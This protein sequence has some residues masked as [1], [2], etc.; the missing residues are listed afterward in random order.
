VSEEPPAVRDLLQVNAIPGLGV[1]LYRRLIERFGSWQN[2]R[3]ASRSDLLSVP[4]L[5]EDVARAIGDLDAFDVTG[6]IEAARHLGIQVVPTTD[7]RF[8]AGL[9]EF[10]GAPL[11]LYVRGELRP[12]DHLAIAMVGSRR[13]THYGR[14]QA[15]RLAYGLAKAGFCIVSGLARGIDAAAHRG[16]LRAGGRTLAVMGCGL[17]TVYPPEHEG[18]AGE[19]EANGALLSELP[20]D[21]PPRGSHF[22]SRNRIIAALSLGVIVV[23]AARRS[24]ALITARWALD[25]N[26]QVYAVPGPVDSRS[27]RGPHALIRDGAKLV[28]SVQDVV[29]ELGPLGIDVPTDAEETIDDPRALTL[30]GNEREIFNAVGNRPATIDAIVEAT[31]LPVPAVSSTL[32]VLEI[33]GLVRQLPGKRFVRP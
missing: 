14:S 25:L 23:E 12:S 7:A 28:E 3:G 31:G 24:G 6:E 9:R 30:K 21:F 22:P 2:V 19:I 33:R 16:A 8:P 15:E 20:L 26:R 4:D 13:C 27:S 29:E 32:M 11:A 1:G 5:D 10:H 17:K 18:L